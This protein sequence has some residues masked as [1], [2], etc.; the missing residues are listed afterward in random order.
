M[1]ILQINAVYGVGSTGVIVEDLHN[2]SLS[3]G[4][5]SY[6]AYST[7]PKNHDEIVNGY[8][9]GN[10]LSKKLHAVLCRVSGKQGYFSQYDTKKLINHIEKIN[11]DIIHLH[12]LHS[13]YI[14]VNMLLRYIAKKN[15][16]TVITLHDCWFYTGGCF[17]YENADC[18][19]WMKN[20]GNCPKRYLEIPAFVKDGSA[21]ILADRKKYVGDIKNLTLVG[22]SN[23]I[24]DEARQSFLKDKNIVT[25]Y[26]G[27]DTEWFSY[28][29]SDFR[30][31]YNLQNK[32]VILGA[33]NKWLKPEN[34]KTL[35]YFSKNLPEDCALVIIGC[36]KDDKDRLPKNVVAIDYV[37]DRD[38]LRKI[39]S[40][41]DVFANCTREDTL[42]LINIE[43]QS[44]GTPSVTYD[45]TGVKETVDNKCGFSVPTGDYKLFFETILKIKE[46]GK[47]AFSADCSKWARE[48]FNRDRNY[49]KYI[50]LYNEIIIKE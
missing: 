24:A 43:P 30:E 10:V 8:K 12:N 15:I 3:K 34:S 16:A 50:D 19:G 37:S 32:F 35:E 22:V 45:N 6:V 40:A 18:K 29:P 7:S 44:C 38:E 5:D 48:R 1:K 36:I 13:N 42:S 46:K 39:Y 4:I 20:C 2:L 27:I 49:E 25:I 23:W 17:Y 14:N 31:R 33:A 26:N 11:P 9:I 41:C 28:T 21:D 47:S